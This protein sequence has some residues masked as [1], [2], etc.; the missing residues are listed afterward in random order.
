MNRAHLR[1][2]LYLHKS[3]WRSRGETE[4]SIDSRS[5][6][7][8][9]DLVAAG[10]ASIPDC[11]GSNLPVELLLGIRVQPTLSWWE[12]VS[13]ARSRI[14][15]LSS[16]LPPPADSDIVALADSDR[17]ARALL[18][19]P[20]AYTALSATLRSGVGAD[21]PACHWLYDILLSPDPDL[22]LTALT[23]LPLLSSLYLLRLPPA[24]PSSLSSFEAVLLAVYSSEAKNRQGKPD[25]V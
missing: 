7:S 12:S 22:L 15:A 14:L 6:K 11:R 25:L 2:V 13:Q 23:F 10:H 20:A 16:I 5:P 9:L 4:R 24:L 17:P 18:R 19:S 21:D 1:L 8:H 3:P